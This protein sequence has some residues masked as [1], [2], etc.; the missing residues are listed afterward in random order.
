MAVLKN[1]CNYLTFLP[2]KDGVEFLSTWIWAGLSDFTLAAHKMWWKWWYMDSKTRSKHALQL[3][4]WS[5]GILGL[6]MLSPETQLPC[7]ENPEP[8]KRP[9][10]GSLVNSTSW[11]RSSSY[12]CKNARYGS[13][14]A[15]CEMNP[16]VLAI[17]LKLHWTEF[18]YMT[19]CE[20][21]FHCY[22]FYMS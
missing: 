10:V 8:R 4:P 2:L 20:T 17:Q 15:I 14:K 21:Y 18:M 7:S 12:P 19:I 9:H 5:L 13:E 16:L 22:K 3:L 1:G 11:A 6:Q